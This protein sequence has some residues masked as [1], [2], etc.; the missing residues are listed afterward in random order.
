MTSGAGAVLYFEDLSVGQS[1]EIA[2]TVGA[3]DIDGFAAVSGD[4]NPVH[5]DADYAA[6]TVFG[7]RVAHGMLAG[8]YISAVLGVKLPGPGAIYRTQSLKFRKPVK[9]GDTVVARVTV[10]ELEERRGLATLETVCLVGEVTVVEGEA[11]V[12]VP[13]RPA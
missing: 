9:I 4:V 11:V 3:A 12:V 7:E 13:R 10:R 8:A 1:A 5:I 6:T 2:R